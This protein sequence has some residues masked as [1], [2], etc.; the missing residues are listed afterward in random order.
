MPA[1]APQ[2]R[3]GPC[4]LPPL[5]GSTSPR[6]GPEPRPRPLGRRG[7][8]RGAASGVIIP[9]GLCL[10]LLGGF[11]R[12]HSTFGL[13]DAFG[14]ELAHL[15]PKP[16]GFFEGLLTVFVVSPAEFQGIKDDA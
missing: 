9:A 2:R 6:S 12:I 13:P 8:A 16:W 4:A 7:W 5:G 15:T 10:H 3:A 14:L 11:I 1:A